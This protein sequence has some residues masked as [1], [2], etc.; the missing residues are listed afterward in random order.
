MLDGTAKHCIGKWAQAG[1]CPFPLPICCTSLSRPPSPRPPLS[2][3]V[4]R[5]TEPR[6]SNLV[7][8]KTQ[9]QVAT[10]KRARFSRLRALHRSFASSAARISSTS[11]ETY[12]I[13]PCRVAWP[14]FAINVVFRNQKTRGTLE[15][16]APL[17]R[18]GGYLSSRIKTIST[19]AKPNICQPLF[20]HWFNSRN[21]KESISN[22]LYCTLRRQPAQ[23][24][25][26]GT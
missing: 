20:R 16:L 17:I 6:R 3:C 15:R 23:S 5:R 10:A 24:E 2:L 7:L 13:F 22:A 19:V 1:R 9:R 11:R 14:A 21:F 8:A 25:A 4:P 12:F 18:K 26:Q